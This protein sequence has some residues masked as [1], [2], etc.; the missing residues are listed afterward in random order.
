[1]LVSFVLGVITGA[2]GLW[3]LGDRIRDQIEVRTRKARTR[4]A[5]ILDTAAGA[6]DT[7]SSALSAAGE[8]LQG[9][10]RER[11]ERTRPAA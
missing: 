4:A 9:A 2:T 6:L 10:P 5:D 3:L 8:S 1:M 11:E 7:A